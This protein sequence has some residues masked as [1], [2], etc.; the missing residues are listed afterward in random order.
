MAF[1]GTIRPA[2]PTDIGDI[3]ALHAIETSLAIWMDA[4][5]AFANREAWFNDRLAA[6]FPVLVAEVGGQFA[7]FASYGP[8]R[9]GDG[10]RHTVENS[11][12]VQPGFTGQ[13]VGRALMLALVGEAKRAGLHIIVAAIGLPNDASV[14][15]HASL[16]FEDAGVLR[17]IGLKNGRRLDLQ[18][19][20]K[21]VG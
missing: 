12:Y 16:G 20:Q 1:S 5:V 15:L 2:T 7:G 6:G 8:F 14:A 9:S 4:P 17:E 13:G 19:M 10:Y 18:M 11:V 21:R 3:L